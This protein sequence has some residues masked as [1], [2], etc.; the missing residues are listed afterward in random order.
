MIKKIASLTA[1]FTLI[2]ITSSFA[3]GW[4]KTNY[5]TWEYYTNDTNT[6]KYEIGYYWIDGNKDGIEEL[7]HFENGNLA[8]S[9]KPYNDICVILNESGTVNTDGQFVHQNGEIAKRSAKVVT[10][11]P[12]IKGILNQLQTSIHYEGNHGRES[13][14][15]T[16]NGT[17]IH[18]IGSSY[19][20]IT[21]MG[22]YY[23]ISN[24]YITVGAGASEDTSTFA[25]GLHVYVWKDAIAWNG[26]DVV[27][28][29]E[30]FNKNGT[31]TID[32]IQTIPFFSNYSTVFDENGYVV[33][34]SATLYE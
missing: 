16:T 30:L 3:S 4:N 33:E 31:L 8:I 27:T 28:A 32:G 2:S 5:G 29:E 6:T 22:T 26:S 24:C 23:D 25:D 19:G 15:Y 20:T 10:A 17:L 9:D 34:F 12:D 1:L 18:T 14:L 7:Y 13:G 11:I 21:D